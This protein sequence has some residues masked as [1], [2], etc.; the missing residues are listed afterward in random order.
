MFLEFS[1]RNRLATCRGSGMTDPVPLLSPSVIAHSR[2]ISIPTGLGITAS[3][4]RA[5]I[6]ASTDTPNPQVYWQVLKK[7]LCTEGEQ[8][9]FTSTRLAHPICRPLH[10]GTGRYRGYGLF[11]PMEALA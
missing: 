9:T 10:L 2:L 5:S 1:T 11:R 4:I 6:Q 8:R 7:L 3:D